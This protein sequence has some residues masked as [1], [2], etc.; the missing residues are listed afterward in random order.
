MVSLEALAFTI[1]ED[2]HAVLDVSVCD[3]EGFQK[4]AKTQANGSFI[5]TARAKASGREYLLFYITLFLNIARLQQYGPA[6]IATLDEFSRARSNFNRK[7][8]R[9]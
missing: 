4:S 2:F 7:G 9:W 3:P 5:R 6:L 8:L 1:P